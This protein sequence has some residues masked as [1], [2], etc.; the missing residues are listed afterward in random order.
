MSDCIRCHQPVLPGQHFL[1]ADYEP[2][3]INDMMLQ[4]EWI[5][6][7]A[8]FLRPTLSPYLLHVTC[9]EVPSEENL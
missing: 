4:P 1:R 9:P 7:G 2:T 6:Q 8:S 5:S 3:D